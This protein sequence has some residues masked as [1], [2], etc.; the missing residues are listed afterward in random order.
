MGWVGLGV[1]VVLGV[2]LFLPIVVRAR[3]AV[4]EREVWGLVDVRWGLLTLR[5]ATDGYGQADL[6]GFRI[7]RFPLRRAESAESRAPSSATTN[8]HASTRSRSWPRRP[9]AALRLVRQGLHAL[10]LHGSIR[11]T[12]GLD[13]PADTAT[14]VA[15]AQLFDAGTPP[16]FDLDI[17]DEL[18]EDTTQVVGQI[19]GWVVPAELAVVGVRWLVEVERHRLLPGRSGRKGNSWSKFRR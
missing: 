10:H 16:C 11:G 3:G 2:V 14:L 9:G 18:L 5:F 6:A 17:Q 15:L 13:D 7:V 12:L 8:E 19:R 1:A 4:G